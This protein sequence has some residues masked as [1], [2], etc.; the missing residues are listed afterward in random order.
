VV[1]V[2][3][4]ST[5]L[6]I[7]KVFD[8]PSCGWAYS[9]DLIDATNHCK[10][11]GADIISMSLG[12]SGKSRAE[13]KAFKALDNDGI[14]SI[15]AAGN[16][17]NTRKSYPASYDSVVS[18]AAVDRNNLVA[19]FSQQNSAVELAAPGVDV[20]S[21]VPWLSTNTVTAAGRT[22]NGGQIENAALGSAAGNL[23]DGGL[24]NSSGNWENRVVL[25]QR[26]DISFLDK[27]SNVEAGD[28]IAAV[29]YN[30]EAGGFSGTLGD[31]NTSA[32]PA[33][34]LSLADGQQLV[35]DN[36]GTSGNV[37]S[38][39]DPSGS[40]YEYWSGTSMATPHVSG[41]AALVWSS[42]LALT[43]TDIR[44]ALT[45]TAH[46]LGDTGRD[47]AY[48]YGL[49]QAKSAWNSLGGSSGS[50]NQAPTASFTASCNELDCTFDGNAS[51]D[52]EEGDLS[53]AWDFGNNAEGTGIISNNLY[54][55]SGTYTI[56][57]TV[58]DDGG[59]TNRQTKNIS[60]SNGSNVTALEISDVSAA[61]TKGTSFAISWTT[62]L[63]ADSTV[64]FTCCGD[65]SNADLLTSHS[66]TFRG[67]KGSS[68]E[69]WVHSRSENGEDKSAGP[70]TF[71]N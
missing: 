57:L 5:S 61:K 62:N 13:D 34:A 26:G 2:N 24:C 64:T 22:Y 6:Y 31:G 58:T 30:N 9:S 40:G 46:D 48:G 15:A 21:T 4:G 44:D 35:A 66:M 1:G 19:D 16:D 7:V 12:G 63:A 49:V 50:T 71:K 29:I 28:G 39:F 11:A 59:A 36:L 33:I 14:L 70:F 51:S 37:V 17:G 60:V 42:D 47:A 67:S 18:V 52:P 53:Y 27:V 3:P 69:Y 38:T 43:N 41:V 65:F 32:I 25:C 45:Q 23:V 55:S 8:G 68:Y 10:E 54:A 20:L 56:S